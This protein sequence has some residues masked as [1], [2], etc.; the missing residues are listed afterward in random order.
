M[1]SITEGTT[2]RRKDALGE[3]FDS[4]VA[5]VGYFNALV[6]QGFSLRTSGGIVSVHNMTEL[7][8]MEIVSIPPTNPNCPSCFGSGTVSGPNG[9]SYTCTCSVIRESFNTCTERDSKTF[10]EW[11]NEDFA[12]YA[13]DWDDLGGIN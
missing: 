1:N 4:T 6:P 11:L 12:E 2:V 3:S 5:E 13:T 9:S 10:L 7:A 8:H